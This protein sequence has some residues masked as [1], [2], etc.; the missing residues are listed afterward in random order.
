MFCNGSCIVCRSGFKSD[1]NTINNMTGRE[2]CQIS[3]LGICRILGGN[4]V[5][6]R[7]WQKERAHVA[8]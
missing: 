5:A 8:G 6:Y 1:V 7:L 4:D 2:E 3:A